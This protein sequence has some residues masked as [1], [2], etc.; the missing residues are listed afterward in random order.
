MWIRSS[1][2]TA[3]L[4]AASIL[5]A[6]C[7]GDDK[8]VARPDVT[9]D[10]IG[11]PGDVSGGQEIAPT[12]DIIEL[13]DIKADIEADIEADIKADIEADTLPDLS[14]LVDGGP[15][16]TDETPDTDP[17][18][19]CEDGEPCED[20]DPCTETGVCV[21]G[22]CVP[23]PAVECEPD[24]NICT[25]AV[26]SS[27]KGG[28]IQEPR[29]G[30]ACND[31]DP[32]TTLTFCDE[33]G[34]CSGV[35]KDCDDGIACTL[36]YCDDNGICR[37]EPR[38]DWCDD[39]E[40]CRGD[41]CDPDHGCL[42]FGVVASEPTQDGALDEW[43]DS[44]VV[45]TSS[46]DSPWEGVALESL[47]VQVSETGLHLGLTA[48]VPDGY[49]W[50]VVLD[51]DH[52]ADEATGIRRLGDL[53]GTESALTAVAADIGLRLGRSDFGGDVLIGGLGA[54]TV[55]GTADEV[56]CRHI[57]APSAPLRI[58]CT[59]DVDLDDATI[60]VTLPWESLEGSVVDL[61]AAGPLAAGFVLLARVADGEI[62]G[63]VLPEQSSPLLRPFIFPLHESCLEPFCGD[64]VVDP[65]EECDGGPDGESEDCVACRVVLPDELADMVFVPEGEFI[66]G[67]EVY[68]GEP[69]NIPERPAHAVWLDSF[70]IERYEVTN[71]QFAEFLNDRGSHMG[72]H[73]GQLYK[74]GDMMAAIECQGGL[75]SVIEGLEDHPVSYV[76]WRGAYEYC[77]W[78]GRRLPTEA[79]WEKAARGPDSGEFSMWYPW[80][81]EF[82][83]LLL[84]CLPFYCP[85]GYEFTAP[86]GSF[87]GGVSYYGAYDMA[88][89]VWEWTNDWFDGSYYWRSPYENPRGPCADQFTCEVASNRVARGG[90]YRDEDT[91]TRSTYRYEA[92]DDCPKL[93]IGMRCALSYEPQ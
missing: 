90:S 23:G 14:D 38:H 68:T 37:H 53:D 2:T 67:R 16:D 49:A 77:K 45:A 64:G 39:G 11:P 42:M 22:R 48:A 46:E 74:C 18:P 63:Q 59:V 26:C 91:R 50:L 19:T 40:P 44:A 10:V 35:P 13:L 79:E 73:G 41:Y 83:P 55:S 17:A 20:S 70:Y 75:Y 32:C 47:A 86:V 81:D 28:C 52:A 61:S 30:L 85:V 15:Q 4:L 21:E 31:G 69:E 78:R 57:S 92:S 24:G 8:E 60:E 7:A 80:G 43:L 76:P 72:P 27:V 34:E 25:Q 3:V 88:G 89:N 29:I 9:P 66:M 84:N 87:P 93:N 65:G 1:L 6:G 56:G 51:L 82:E 54:A 36:D 33:H 5:F 71:E 12:T 58:D 62:G